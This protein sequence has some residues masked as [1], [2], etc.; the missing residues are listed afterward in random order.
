MKMTNYA[1]MLAVALNCGTSFA[2]DCPILQTLPQTQD[3]PIPSWK[4]KEAGLMKGWTDN[5]DFYMQIVSIRD[6]HG[7]KLSKN[8][9]ITYQFNDGRTSDNHTIT[10]KVLESIRLDKTVQNVKIEKIKIPAEAMH[11][12]G[13]GIFMRVQIF[14]PQSKYFNYYRTGGEVP[15]DGRLSEVKDRRL[16]QKDFPLPADL[17]ANPNE[18]VAIIGADGNNYSGDQYDTYSDG[19]ATIIAITRVPKNSDSIHALSDHFHVGQE[20][21]LVGNFG[22]SY[23]VQAINRDTGLLQIK[24]VQNYGNMNKWAHALEVENVMGQNTDPQNS[25]KHGDHVLLVFDADRTTSTV[26]TVAKTGGNLVE[27]NGFENIVQYGDIKPLTLVNA[28][29][30]ANVGDR[31][32]LAPA[33]Y[34]SQD[35]FSADSDNGHGSTRKQYLEARIKEANKCV[36]KVKA[37]DSSGFANLEWDKSSCDFNVFSESISNNQDDFDRLNWIHLSALNKAN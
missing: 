14:A 5:Y 7:A 3:K 32:T 8:S 31:V 34:A 18:F 24:S 11:I 37:L 13:S 19:P 21:T 29:C 9:E 1:L 25:Y 10:S 35:D 33:F 28:I 6:K 36:A 22:Q 4:N 17:A 27:V 16:A 20:V 2:L 12:E 23:L 15:L 30:G 26:G